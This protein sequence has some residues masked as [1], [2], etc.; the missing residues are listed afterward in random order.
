MELRNKTK[1]S[2]SNLVEKVKPFSPRGH[3]SVSTPLDSSFSLPSLQ[4][5]ST[6]SPPENPVTTELYS[7]PIVSLTKTVNMPITDGSHEFIA[8]SRLLEEIKASIQEHKQTVAQ[9]F[10]KIHETQRKFEERI[11]Q[12]IQSLTD[13]VKARVAAGIKEMTEYVDG[14][15]GRVCTQVNDVQERVAVLEDKQVPEYDPEVSIILSKVP[16]TQDEDIRQVTEKIIHDELS[17]PDVQVVRACRLRQ[18]NLPGDQAAAA[19]PLVKV[20]FKDLQTKLRVLQVK[21]RIMN[22][23]QYS[24]VFIRSSKP[25]V[26]RMMHANNQEILRLLGQQ[27]QHMTVTSSGRIVKKNNPN[28]RRDV[29][30]AQ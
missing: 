18:R 1:A 19:P 7:S 10:S 2:L 5:D 25:H 22:S 17:L 13:D 6:F 23:A 26:E 16:V 3:G 4:V 30:G 21:K 14:E 29:A 8:L 9:E 27:A 20:Q 24:N 12:Q 28:D 11:E 15:M